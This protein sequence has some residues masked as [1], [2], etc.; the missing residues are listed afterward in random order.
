[1]RD[2]VIGIANKYLGMTDFTPLCNLYNEHL[3]ESGQLWGTRQIKMLTSWGWCVLFTSAVGIE[4]GLIKY[5]PQEIGPWEVMQIAKNHNLWQDKAYVPKKADLILFNYSGKSTPTHIG[6][7][8]SVENGVIH[9]I[10]GNSGSPRQ[11]CK[12]GYNIG[13]SSI[14]GYICPN[15]TQLSPQPTPDKK[16][17]DEQIDEIIKKLQDL[18]ASLKE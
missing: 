16:G 17:V 12:K 9:T 11:V 2:K 1:M 18:K 5:V 8:E 3:K 15:Y 10:E 6:F 13:D 14:V 7:V 4:A